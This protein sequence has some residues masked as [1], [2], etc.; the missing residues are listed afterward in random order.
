MTTTEDASAPVPAA[1]ANAHVVFTDLDGVEGVIVDLN[2][3]QYFTLNQTACLV[4]RGIAGGRT[5]VEIASDMSRAYEV[6]TEHAEASTR[7][8]LAEL[9]RMN[10]VTLHG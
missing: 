1:T 2:T 8:V 5:V 6:S 3:K 9:A 10:L 7:T 4:W